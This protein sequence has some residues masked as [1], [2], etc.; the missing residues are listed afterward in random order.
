MNYLL[1]CSVILILIIFLLVNNLYKKTNY[2]NNQILE[3]SKYHKEN[4]NNLKIVNLGSTYAQFAFGN[5]DELKLNGFSFALQSKSLKL[6]Y[7]ILL[8]Y[9]KWLS[10]K[11]VVIIPLAPCLLLY[12][13]DDYKD[14]SPFAIVTL[15]KFYHVTTDYLLGVSEQKNHSDSEL[16]AL[17][18]SDDAIDVLKAG[19]FNPRLLSEIL[20]H[21]DFQKMMLDAEI[22]VDRIADMRISDMNA[23][24]QAVR[25][26]VLMQQGETEN[27]LY[28]RTL[29]LA[30][31]Q[32]D[33]Y[34]GHVIS[35]DLKL[36]LRDIREAHKKDATTADRH[37]PAL[38]VQQ[39]LQEAMDYKGSDA[40]KQARIF[41]ATFGIDYDAITM[42][43][44]V[45][46][47]EVL[48]LSKHLK[49]SINQ[50]GKTNMTHG[51][52]KRKRK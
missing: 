30:Q 51:K 28:L 35:D 1:I 25:Q 7:K 24:L 9:S 10:E 17:H 27:D 31:V 21:H 3:I 50:R 11:C 46:I 32:E 19:K 23:V 8:K 40:E 12:E 5:Y 29:E 48:K 36:I 18:L 26:M 22:Y 39:S 13:N 16:S 38:D 44:F 52:G 49:P 45:N 15:A 4:R 34:F 41:L 33:E 2:Y 43:Q 14:I 42:E 47:I 6:D 37:S 20:C